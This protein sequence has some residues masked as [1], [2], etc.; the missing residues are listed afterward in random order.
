VRI[1][2]FRIC[3]CAGAKGRISRAWRSAWLRAQRIT[4]GTGAGVAMVALAARLG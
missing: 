2:C 3:C 4:E 1:N